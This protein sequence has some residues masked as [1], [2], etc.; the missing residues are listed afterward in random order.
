VLRPATPYRKGESPNF[1]GGREE[2]AFLP[3]PA[4]SNCLPQALA[5]AQ[6][7]GAIHIAA[8][9]LVGSLK[10]SSVP[11]A[12]PASGRSRC[13]VG[14]AALGNAETRSR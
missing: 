7:P 10:S 14:E 4:W 11:S 9:S 2:G 3:L 12:G 13:F 5:W 8:W 1:S 6:D